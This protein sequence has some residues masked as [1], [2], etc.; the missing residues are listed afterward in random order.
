MGFV[1]ER[2]ERYAGQIVAN[3][4]CVRFV[5]EAGDL[6]HTGHWRPGRKA[7][8]GAL[9]HGTVI[10]T[11]DPNNRYG[12]HTDGRSHAA[13][14]VEETAAG[15]LVWDQWLRHPVAQRVI[16]FRGGRGRRVNDG[17]QFHVVETEDSLLAAEIEGLDRPPPAA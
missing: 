11:F 5:Q 6:P 7:R 9:P 2:P 10:A 13:I 14:F 1:V 3:G 4:H 12:N 8:G 15:L 17:D 16:A